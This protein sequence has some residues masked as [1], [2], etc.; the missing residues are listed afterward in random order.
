MSQEVPALLPSLGIK[1]GGVQHV[2]VLSM[3]LGLFLLFIEG[4]MAADWFVA[5]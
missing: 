3:L 2:V 4:L 1:H 5:P